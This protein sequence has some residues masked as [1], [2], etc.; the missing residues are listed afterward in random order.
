L[1]TAFV[2][3]GNVI[4]TVIGGYVLINY[5]WGMLGLVL[6]VFGVLASLIYWLFTEE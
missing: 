5:G 1:N 4:G 3:V 6:G 2:N